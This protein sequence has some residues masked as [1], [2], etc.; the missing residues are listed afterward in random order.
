MKFKLPVLPWGMSDLEPFLTSDAIECHYF[1]HHKAY[2]DKVN[3]LS[4]KLN[5]R[6]LTLEKII[7]NYDG[8]IFNNAAQ[9]WNHTFFWHG[10]KPKSAKPHSEGNFGKAVEEQ[11]DSLT[12]LRERFMDCATNLFGS[13]WTWFVT[14]DSGEVDVIN[15]HN[16]DNPIRFENM[17]PLWACD[18]WEH[19][20]YVD[21]RNERKQYLEGI[22]SHINWSFVEANYN[23]RQ[24]PNMSRLMTATDLDEERASERL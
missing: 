22:W 14:S 9:A 4:A 11:F 18:V 5:L 3:E 6:N 8:T 13:G 15:T 2:I 16:G 12:G 21:Y 23:L 1:G 7:L 17:R 24:I 10:L 20:Y 19:A